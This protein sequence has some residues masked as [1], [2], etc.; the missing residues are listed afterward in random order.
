LPEFDYSNLKN[1]D[2]QGLFRY[3]AVYFHLDLNAESYLRFFMDTVIEFMKK[4][5]SGIP[6][7]LEWWEEKSRTASLIIPE[8]IDAVR[9]MTIHKAKGLQFPVVIY[10]FA[11]EE[12]RPTRKNLWVPLEDEMARPLAVAYLPARKA[13][14]GTIYEPLYKD[15]I[16]RSGIDLVNVL[17]VALTRPEDRLYVITKPLPDKTEGNITVP[18]LFS[19]FFRAIG[20]YAADRSAYLF[21][22]KLKKQA[23]EPAGIA[24]P[25]SD[26]PFMGKASLDLLLRKHAP[27]N[28]D[29]DDP[30][31][32]REWGVLVH[33]LLSGIRDV[34]DISRA[35]EEMLANGDV[36]RKQ[37]ASLEQ[38][39]GSL[40]KDPEFATLF[41]PGYE[42]LNEA[43][44]ITSD[45]QSF[46]PDRVMVRGKDAIIVEYKTGAVKP[47]HRE[48]VANYARL[49]QQM[50]YNVRSASLVYLE[51]KPRLIRVI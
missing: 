20:D 14:E 28:W 39:A 48:Q 37:A 3:L 7:F 27:P 44:I 30:D 17:Y 23:I 4:N 9:I 42:M 34:S 32:Y 31:A 45:G 16:D 36:S 25:A 22:Q 10:P 11:D 8:G 43:E 26:E 24:T 15:E 49:L 35:V 38:L 19:Y 12:C 21:G 33:A 51:E 47:A 6:E 46:R 29:M 18:K 13:L 2:L 41:E 40:I 50:D 5:H 1:L